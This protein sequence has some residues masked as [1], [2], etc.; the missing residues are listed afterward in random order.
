MCFL[1]LSGV[2]SVINVRESNLRGIF[3]DNIFMFNHV[4]L[5]K[6]NN[7]WEGC[8]VGILNGSIVRSGLFVIISLKT[9]FNQVLDIFVSSILKLVKL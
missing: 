2:F 8:V 6:D 1:E 5:K 4:F 3:V 9:L 7:G